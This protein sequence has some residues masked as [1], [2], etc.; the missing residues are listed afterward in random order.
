M[1]ALKLTINIKT[2]KCKC[3]NE[4]EVPKYAIDPV[5]AKYCKACIKKGLQNY[6]KLSTEEVIKLHLKQVIK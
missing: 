6:A 4:F 1:K 5:Y 3:G 2:M